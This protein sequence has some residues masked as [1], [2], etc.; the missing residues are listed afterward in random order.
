MAVSVRSNV[1]DERT[2]GRT[3][4]RGD[5]L[6]ILRHAVTS[7][8]AMRYPRTMTVTSRLITLNRPFPFDAS[9]IDIAIAFRMYGESDLLIPRAAPGFYDSE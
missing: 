1:I 9:G 6:S 3:L 7:I 8:R 2:G 4:R 5:S